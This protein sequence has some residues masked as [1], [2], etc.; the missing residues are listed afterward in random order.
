MFCLYIQVPPYPSLMIKD[1][2]SL[3]KWCE[4]IGLKIG[5]KPEGWV[6]SSGK[7]HSVHIGRVA[8]AIIIIT[9]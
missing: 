2:T 9:I 4:G 6:P 8:V 7:D 1:P 5:L 3:L